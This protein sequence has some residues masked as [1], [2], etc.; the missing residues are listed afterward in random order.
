MASPVHSCLA[1]AAQNDKE[2][3][4][5]MADHVTQMKSIAGR[6]E[7]VA[8][9]GAREKRFLDE[10]DKMLKRVRSQQEE[11]EGLE[12]Q[13]RETKA[14]LG[15]SEKANSALASLLSFQSEQGKTLV[16]RKSV[17]NLGGA[18]GGGGSSPGLA[19]REEV[20]SAVASLE[21]YFLE[22]SK[23]WGHASYDELTSLAGVT[24]LSGNSRDDLF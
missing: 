6:M 12:D 4:D 23:K 18:G 8:D 22:M 21:G 7:Q 16:R 11:L 13:V 15:R 1:P 14:T 9:G 5:S 17:L 10:Q 2:W 19:P 20:A 24:N 3:R